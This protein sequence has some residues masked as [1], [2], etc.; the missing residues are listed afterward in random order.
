MTNDDVVNATPPPLLNCADDDTVLAGTGPPPPPF[1]AKLAVIANDALAI[2]PSK[3][4]AVDAC[5]A[6]LEVVAKLDETATDAV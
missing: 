4:D 1:S 3:K 2:V 6:K 5:V